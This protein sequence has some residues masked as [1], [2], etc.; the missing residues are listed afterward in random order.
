MLSISSV[1]KVCLVRHKVSFR[2]GHD[3]LLGIAYKLGLN[4]YQGDLVVFVGRDKKRIKLLF[5]DDKGLSVWYKLLHEGSLKKVFRFA[6]DPLVTSI[7][8]PEVGLLM[9][10]VHY[11]IHNKNN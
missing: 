1:K 7:S 6:T 10:G 3:G 9:E 5:G 2:N 4:P 8:L 11:T